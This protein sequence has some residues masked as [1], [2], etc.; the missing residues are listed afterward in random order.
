MAG[1]VWQWVADWYAEDSYKIGPNRNPRGPEAGKSRVARGGSWLD[2]PVALATS[3]RH[4]ITPSYAVN[5]LG[6]RCAKDP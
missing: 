3:F 6:F 4:F 1:N 5:V 2:Q